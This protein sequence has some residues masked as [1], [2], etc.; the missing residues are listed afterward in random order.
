[1]HVGKNNIVNENFQTLFKS[2]S[3]GI[4]FPDLD[5]VMF[6]LRPHLALSRSQ[7][8]PFHDSMRTLFGYMIP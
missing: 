3:D 4:S 6:V 2:F 1:M 8:S 7:T 5:I